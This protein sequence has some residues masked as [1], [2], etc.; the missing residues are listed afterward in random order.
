M[1]IN[2]FIM[3]NKHQGVYPKLSRM[4]TQSVKN[5][6]EAIKPLSWWLRW[7]KRQNPLK[8]D[9]FATLAPVASVLLFFSAIAFSFW[10]LKIEEADREQEAVKRDVEYSQQ[11]LRLRLLERQEQ[12]MRLARD[13][14][15]KDVDLKEFSR[16][17]ESL[18]LKNPEI[19]TIAW[20]DDQRKV[21]VSQNAP[22]VLVS[23]KWRVGEVLKWGESENSFTLARDLMQPIYSQEDDGSLSLAS[24]L[25][26]QEND[27]KNVVLQLH[28]PLTNAQGRFN[29]V[30]MAEYAVESL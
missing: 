23:Q 13:V 17:A 20:I 25:S 10:Y 3:Q 19:K 21:L 2:D 14:S 30:I 9:R 15:N 4:K 12:I 28:T 29:G 5:A 18:V 6:I 27:A 8:Q 22:S 24:N 26:G 7:W 1:A 11:R 16:R